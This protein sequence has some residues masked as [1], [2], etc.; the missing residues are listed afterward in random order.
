M[1]TRYT[2]SGPYCYAN[3]IAMLT[4][5]DPSAVEVLTG[6]PFGLWLDDDRLPFFDPYGWDPLAGSTAALAR[7]GWSSTVTTG[8]E[9]E[10]DGDAIQRLRLAVRDRPALVGPV[11][12]GL[13][14]HLPEMTGP[15]GSDHYVVVT[16]VAGDTVVFHDPHGCPY[17]T[18]PAGAFA[19]AWRADSIDYTGKPFVMRTELEKT[20]NVDL[21]TAFTEFVPA[22]RK[23]LEDC[24]T[25]AGGAS[26]ALR[27]ADLVEAGLPPDSRGH[28][29]HFAVRVG[30]RR[31]CDAAHWLG[32]IGRASAA[33][34]LSRQAKLV[35]SLQY[36]LTAGSAKAAAETFRQL[37]PTYEQLHAALG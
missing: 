33:D 37:A 5:E 24:D 13:L 4:G 31:L 26:A 16:E 8:S 25:P 15:I 17:A 30:V 14:R 7:L 19:A 29:V 10:D 18:L 34:V 20:E 11:E 1:T 28:L 6:S 12:I 23:L 36:E 21:D 32:R 9:E 3:S 22:A 35:G 2:G 27:L